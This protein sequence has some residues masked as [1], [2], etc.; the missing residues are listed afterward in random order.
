MFSEVNTKICIKCNIEKPI[1]EFYNARNECIKCHNLRSANYYTKNISK[2]KLRHRDYYYNNREK[3][4]KKS[5]NY[6]SKNKKKIFQR[7]N[8]YFKLRRKNDPA[9]RI[10]GILSTR[11]SILLRQNRTNKNNSTLEYLGTSF[12]NFIKHLES[13]WYINPRTKEMM[14]WENYG[15][16]GWHVDH[17]IPCS[18]FNLKNLDAQKK[19]FHYKNLRPLWAEDNLKRG[20]KLNYEM[21]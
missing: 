12:K 3:K 19:C 20:N 13:Q 16:K 6:Y 2:I 17:I 7:V 15:L 10:R 4:C 8:K 5:K 21:E 1:I 18:S 9:F 11:I 14:T